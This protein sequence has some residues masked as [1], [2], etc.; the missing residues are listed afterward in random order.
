M[1]RIRCE[2]C[3]RLRA[4][5]TPI[6]E[7]EDVISMCKECAESFAVF[8]RLRGHRCVVADLR[9][10]FMYEVIPTAN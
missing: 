6:F 9:T 1:M 10:G 4:I 8:V 3:G 5:C 7:D 2:C